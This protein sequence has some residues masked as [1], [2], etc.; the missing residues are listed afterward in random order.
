MFVYTTFAALVA[1]LLSEAQPKK[2][3]LLDDEYVG[4]KDLIKK[5]TL[6]FLEK[7]KSKRLP[8]FN[9]GLVG[10]SSPAHILAARVAHKKVEPN[11]TVSLAE[12]RE[13]IWG[14]K[15]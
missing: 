9:F 3:V 15:K 2:K 7:M 1:I 4:H 12:L 10:K 11:R 5:Q 14:N 8:E 13:I 6:E